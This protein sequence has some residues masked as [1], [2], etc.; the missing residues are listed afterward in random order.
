[1][2]LDDIDERT[3]AGSIGF[4]GGLLGLI[5][6]VGTLL[7]V[8]GPAKNSMLDQFVVRHITLFRR[9]LW[10]VFFGSI[11]TLLCSFRGKGRQRGF[12]AA[13]SIVNFLFSLCILGAGE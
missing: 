7:I 10:S 2:N 13:L 4:Y 8:F 5:L 11:I 12:G 1:V 3:V 9:A 6:V